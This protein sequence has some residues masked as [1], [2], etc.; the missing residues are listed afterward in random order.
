MHPR[1][2]LWV[3]MQETVNSFNLIGPACGS[4]G[5][6]NRGTSMR[7]FI[8]WRGNEQYAYVAG[9]NRMVSRS[10]GCS[11]LPLLVVYVAVDKFLYCSC[12]EL[13][14]GLPH[15]LMLRVC[16]AILVI[17]AKHATWVLE[18]PICSLINRHDRWE[19]LCNSVLRVT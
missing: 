18:H 5:L 8:N 9:A 6:P 11:Q 19:W 2:V 14:K 1:L 12:V 13:L 15:G 4:W 16:L 17:T 10:F 3:I 7:N